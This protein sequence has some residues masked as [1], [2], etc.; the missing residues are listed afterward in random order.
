[1]PEPKLTNRIHL[2]GYSRGVAMCGESFLFYSERQNL[3]VRDPN[4][5]TCPDCVNAVIQVLVARWNELKAKEAANNEQR[6]NQRENP[7]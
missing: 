2:V 7:H 1:M 5:S 6:Q 4:Q 3:I